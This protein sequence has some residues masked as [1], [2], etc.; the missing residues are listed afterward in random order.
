MQ[1]RQTISDIE[2]RLT[3]NDDTAFRPLEVSQA[4]TLIKDPSQRLSHEP[5]VLQISL[6]LFTPGLNCRSGALQEAYLSTEIV[7][8]ARGGPELPITHQHFVPRCP[9]IQH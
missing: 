2:A 5:E 9:P 4:A 8:E 3:D 6:V 1:V 7:T